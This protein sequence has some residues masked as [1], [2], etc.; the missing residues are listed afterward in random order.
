MYDTADSELF[1]LYFKEHWFLFS[2]GPFWLGT[3]IQIVHLNRLTFDH[4]SV[5]GLSEL[6]REVWL[7]YCVFMGS[8]V[9]K[10]ENFNPYEPCSASE[11]Y[12]EP[13]ADRRLQVISADQPSVTALTVSH[14]GWPQGR[15]HQATRHQRATPR[16]RPGQEKEAYARWMIEWKIYLSFPLEQIQ[17]YHITYIFLRLYGW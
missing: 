5:F 7:F 2:S 4:I 3:L 17:Q 15:R 16:L 11:G 6:Y 13:S 10:N 12:P 8:Y 14:S 1:S 9:L